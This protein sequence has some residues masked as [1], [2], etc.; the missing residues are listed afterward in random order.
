MLTYQRVKC[1]GKEG[2]TKDAVSPIIALSGQI[3][4]KKAMPNACCFVRVRGV[5][6]GERYG[7]KD[8]KGRNS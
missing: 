2:L 8:A 4:E 1:K 5:Y 6:Y 7:C 3:N